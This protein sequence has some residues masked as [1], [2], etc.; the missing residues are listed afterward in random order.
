MRVR[1]IDPPSGVPGHAAEIS[2]HIP[3]AAGDTSPR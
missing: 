1:H 2:D 3:E